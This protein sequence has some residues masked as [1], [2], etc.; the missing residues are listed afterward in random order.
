MRTYH[1]YSVKYKVGGIPH[2][3]SFVF[4][5][6][7]TEALALAKEDLEHNDQ[8]YDVEVVREY[9]LYRAMR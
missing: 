4:A 1:P 5:H 3:N 9:R 2:G 8:A 7:K 6:N